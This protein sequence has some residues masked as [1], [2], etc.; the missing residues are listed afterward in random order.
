MAIPATSSRYRSSNPTTV[1]HATRGAVR[2]LEFRLNVF[3][4]VNPNDQAAT[5]R[6]GDTYDRMSLKYYG[7]TLRWWVLA[8]RNSDP[9][10]P[11]EPTPGTLLAIPS[12][13]TALNR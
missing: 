8:E 2:V 12:L 6:A 10:W 3:D 1:P 4:R 13:A 11:L 5:S 7:T 9:F